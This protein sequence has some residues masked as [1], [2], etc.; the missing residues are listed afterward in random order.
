[1]ADHIFLSRH[2]FTDTI[3][4]NITYHFLVFVKRS[5]ALQIHPNF[6]NATLVNDIALLRL[7]RRARRK[8]NIDV[9]SRVKLKRELLLATNFLR[10]A[11]ETCCP[12]A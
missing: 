11:L 5:F 6:N 4:Q 8:Q 1:M 3:K 7:V 12:R 2:L 10:S 9:V